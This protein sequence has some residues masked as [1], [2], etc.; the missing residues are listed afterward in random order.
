MQYMKKILLFNIYLRKRI[1]RGAVE[2]YKGNNIMEIM[3]KCLKGDN[4]AIHFALREN[5][6]IKFVQYLLENGA[7][8]NAVGYDNKTP[9]MRANKNINKETLILLLSQEN[10][11]IFAED[12][13]GQ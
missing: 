10:L 4:E 11:D 5:R 7:N 13:D 2:Y 12:G 1:L 3:D 9:I 6:D 8:I